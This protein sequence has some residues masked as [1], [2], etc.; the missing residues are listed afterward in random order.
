MRR[1]TPPPPEV[2]K[3]APAAVAAGCVAAPE[4][5]LPGLPA[6]PGPGPAARAK[7]GS[8][9]SS[10]GRAM[11]TP[12]ARRKRRRERARRLETNGPCAA[13]EGLLRFMESPKQ[14]RYDPA[15]FR[16]NTDC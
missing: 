16:L 1:G 8:I 7:G 14:P 12:A 2:F 11:A 10:M 5:M 4:A 13:E 15:A 3:A 6:F 9:T